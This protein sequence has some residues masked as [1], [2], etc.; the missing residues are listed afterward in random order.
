MQDGAT[1]LPEIAVLQEKIMLTVAQI[2]DKQ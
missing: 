2:F 1:T